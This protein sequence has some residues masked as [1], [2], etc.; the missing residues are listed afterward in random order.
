MVGNIKSG[1][2]AGGGERDETAKGRV[3]VR[4]L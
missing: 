4:M 3:I 2:G 1:Q